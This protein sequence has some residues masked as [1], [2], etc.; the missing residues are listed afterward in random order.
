MTET[1]LLSITAFFVVGAVAAAFI[2]HWVLYKNYHY[3]CTKCSSS[4][5]PANFW[6][7]FFGLNGGE[8]RKLKCPRCNAREWADVKKDK[9]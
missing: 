7:S 9:A 1:V 8:Q 4:Y 3:I 6:Q 2:A 5:K